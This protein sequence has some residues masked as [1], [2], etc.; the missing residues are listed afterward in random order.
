M[1]IQ[2]EIE[3]VLYES[4]YNELIESY[5]AALFREDW[6]EAHDLLVKIYA[7]NLSQ[8]QLILS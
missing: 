7:N 1:E 2:K 4:G 6:K 8:F 5:K 3:V